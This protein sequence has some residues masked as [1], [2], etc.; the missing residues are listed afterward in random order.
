[1]NTQPL[2]EHHPPLKLQCLLVDDELTAMGRVGIITNA[3]AFLAGYNLRLLTVVQ[4]VSQLDAAFGDKEARTFATNHGQRIHYA[5]RV[6][7]DADRYGAMLGHIIERAPS[8]GRSL[9]F[10]SQ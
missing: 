10:S 4:A 1:M 2:P 3:A 6:Q 5:P 9:S 7:R 8:R